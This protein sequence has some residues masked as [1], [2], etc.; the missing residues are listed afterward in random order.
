M[1]LL[2]QMLFAHGFRSFPNETVVLS[3]CMR[4]RVF[5]IERIAFRGGWRKSIK[6]DSVNQALMTVRP[7]LFEICEANSFYLLFKA[8]FT[9]VDR[10]VSLVWLC[11]FTL[12]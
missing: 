8:L 12:N 9:K 1:L 3:S 10:K 4:A 7:L 6:R 11:Y 5:L 2:E